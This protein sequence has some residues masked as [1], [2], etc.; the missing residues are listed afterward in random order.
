MQV[1]EGNAQV[2]YCHG[3]KINIMAANYGRM[4]GAHIC[5]GPI[6]TTHCG[7]AGAFGKVRKD[8]QGR[9]FCLLHAT[10]GKFGD[11]CFG[12]RKY[13][14][15]RTSLRMKHQFSQLKAVHFYHVK[16]GAS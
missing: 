15:V 7:A 9:R 4:T 2:L 11:P 1:C 6:Q 3:K 10:N 13:L 12:T 8:C 16:D 5:P 14:E